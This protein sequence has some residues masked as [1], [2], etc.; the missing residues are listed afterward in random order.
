MFFAVFPRTSYTAARRT[1]QHH[2]AARVRQYY[3]PSAM[4]RFGV[5]P[6]VAVQAPEGEL[7]RRRDARRV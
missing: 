6:A 3:H 5:A 2:G 7:M 1:T 4:V